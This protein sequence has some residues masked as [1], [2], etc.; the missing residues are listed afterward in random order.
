VFSVLLSANA[1]LE[2]SLVPE[3]IGDSIN[4]YYNCTARDSHHF[5]LIVVLQA[6]SA[7]IAQTSAA[8]GGNG[9]DILGIRVGIPPQEAYTQLQKLD[10]AHR[11]TVGQVPIP[12][13]LGDKAAVYAMAPE[14]LNGGLN[15]TINISISVPPTRSRFFKSTGPSINPFI[16]L[17]I[18]SWSR[19]ARNTAQN[20][21]RTREVFQILQ[22]C[23]GC[24]TEKDSWPIRQSV[25][26][27]L[28][29]CGNNYFQFTS[30]GNFPIAGQTVQPG[31][32]TSAYGSIPPFRSRR[33]RILE[34]SSMRGLATCECLRSGWAKQW[35]LQL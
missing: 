29:L 22:I 28:R 20:P 2:K 30:A 26:R 11:V 6:R 35:R 14:S 5:F 7:A 31:A 16:P 9:P 32:L 1:Q 24:M 33:S 4:G 27:L 15:E 25:Q 18:R 17:W 34:K 8:P 21:L 3:A 23:S 12:A 19:Y 13:L 10:P